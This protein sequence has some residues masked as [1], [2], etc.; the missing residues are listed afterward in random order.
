M[1]AGAATIHLQPDHRSGTTWAGFSFLVEDL[2]ESGA[3]PVWVPRDLTGYDANAQ[4]RDESWNVLM[5]MTL[6]DG[7]TI[8]DPAAGVVYVATPDDPDELIAPVGK[9]SFDIK[10]TLPAGQK[11]VE[12]DGYQMVI[13]G[14]TA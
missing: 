12:L 14:V 4:F 10:M 13:A 1:A 2:D 7:I 11:K 3:T 9:M 8:P 6:G 5:D